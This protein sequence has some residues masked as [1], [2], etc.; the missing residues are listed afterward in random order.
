MLQRLLSRF[1][2]HPVRAAAIALACALSPGCQAGLPQPLAPAESESAPLVFVHGLNGAM[3]ADSSGDLQYVTALQALGLSTPDLRL[4]LEWE[5]GAQARDDLQALRPVL[6]VPVLPGV[7]VDVYRPFVDRM[8]AREGRPFFAFAYDWRRDNNENA[9][10][11]REFLEALR[12]DYGRPARIVA[13]SMGGMLTLAA[14][15]EAPELVER[16]VFAGVPFKGGPGYLD[17]LYLGTSIGFNGELLGPE[18]IFSHPSVYSFFPSDQPWETQVVAADAEGRPLELDFYSLEAWRKNGFG[19]YAPQN[20][21]WAADAKRLTERE[22]FLRMTLSRAKAFRSRLTPRRPAAAY[23]PALVVMSRVHPTLNRIRRIPPA[24]EESVPRW[25]FE[26]EPKQ[27]GDGSV[28]YAHALPPAPIA[29]DV[30]LTSYDHVGLLND[31]E[32]Q[33]AIEAFFAKAE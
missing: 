28:L 18:V 11:L 32:A 29:C 6:E 12:S 20:A 24:P 4:P 10:R 7:A 16:V 2:A 23:P 3:L 25:D 27:P 14:L 1:R 31:P 8:L 17:N 9:D 22:T 5:D 19:M 33:D 30:Q 21:E 13:H 26:A 15:N